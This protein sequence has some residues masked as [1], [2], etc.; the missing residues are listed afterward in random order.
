[1]GERKG[2]QGRDDFKRGPR[3]LSQGQGLTQKVTRTDAK[4]TRL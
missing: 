3:L 1:M 2:E 4:D